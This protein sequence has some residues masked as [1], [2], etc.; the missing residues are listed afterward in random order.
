MFEI[1]RIP[2]AVAVAALAVHFRNPFAGGMAGA[3][4]QVFVVGTERPTGAFVCETGPLLVVMTFVAC[5][6]PVAIIADRMDLFLCLGQLGRFVDI[7]TIATVLFLVTVHAPETK[8][9]D[10]FLV[11]ERHHRPLLIGGLVHFLHRLGDNR[12]GGPHD[13]GGVNQRIG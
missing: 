1:G 7:V 9:V 2:A 12:V 4:D 10:M 13:V 5:S 8:Q 6:F 11:A 3:A